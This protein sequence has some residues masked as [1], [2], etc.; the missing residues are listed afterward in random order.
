MSDV[1]L[2][3]VISIKSR[4]GLGYQNRP[5]GHVWTN[6]HDALL[7]QSTLNFVK[8]NLSRHLNFVTIL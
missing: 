3:W 5:T 7:L 6:L 1:G 2:G 4:V 8:R